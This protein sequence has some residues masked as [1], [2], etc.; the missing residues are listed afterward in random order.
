[1]SRKLNSRGFHY[2]HSMDADA[3]VGCKG[4]ADICPDAAIEIDREVSGSPDKSKTSS[5]KSA[6]KEKK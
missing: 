3:C 1:M 6:Q 2:P 4:C 5:S